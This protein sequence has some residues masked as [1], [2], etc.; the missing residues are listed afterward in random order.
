MPIIANKNADDCQKQVELLSRQLKHSQKLCRILMDEYH[1]VR[2]IQ[3]ALGRD[4]EQAASDVWNELDY[5]IQKLLIT[6][7][8]K[9]GPFTTEERA[10]VKA[11]WQISQQDI[12]GY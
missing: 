1:T 6:A 2:S 7:P 12:E 8:R 4:D 10:K 11:I 5:H 3:Y 9:G